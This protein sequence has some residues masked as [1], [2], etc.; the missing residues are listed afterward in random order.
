V[1]LS[2]RSTSVPVGW[3]VAGRGVDGRLHLVQA[4]P[5]G[6][7]VRLQA[8]GNG[9]AGTE[10]LPEHAGV[11]L[12]EDVQNLL[13][14]VGRAAENLGPVG[15]ADQRHRDDQH[16]RVMPAQRQRCRDD[17]FPPARQVLEN[18]VG[19]HSLPEHEANV[20]RVIYDRVRK[21]PVQFLCERRLARAEPAVDPN[22]HRHKLSG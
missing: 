10:P 20:L 8:A 14:R 18:A 11:R 12:Q 19:S 3:R 7:L 15:V 1:S 6:C 4:E 13:A 16:V 2:D 9:H 22:D 17:Q 21:P 5:A